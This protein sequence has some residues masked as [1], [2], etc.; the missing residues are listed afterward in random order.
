MNRNNF[1]KWALIA[2]VLGWSLYEI[3]P[4]QGKPLVQQFNESAGNRDTNFNAIV[5]R[6]REL[7]NERP[8]REFQNLVDAIGTN[9]LKR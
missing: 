6:A 3:Y 4:P 8:T 5:S 9:D 2:F 7:G 1:W